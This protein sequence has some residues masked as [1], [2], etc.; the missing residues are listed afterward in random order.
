[1]A[2]KELFFRCEKCRR[3]YSADRN[4]VQA[5]KYSGSSLASTFFGGH[6]NPF[7]PALKCT[8]CKGRLRR[9]TYEE[10]LASLEKKQENANH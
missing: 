4:G 5:E 8:E 6:A 3:I 2:P 7:A 9:I 10:Y 1:L